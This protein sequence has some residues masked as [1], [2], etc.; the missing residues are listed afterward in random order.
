LIRTGKS[1]LQGQQA[2]GKESK[3]NKLP[4]FTMFGI[5]KKM[6]IPK[7]CQCLLAGDITSTYRNKSASRKI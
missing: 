4:I 3:T 2:V 1:R 7:K 6:D 5:E